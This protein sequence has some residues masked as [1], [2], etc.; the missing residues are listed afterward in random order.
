MCGKQRGYK[1][2]VFV[3]AATKGVTDAFFVSAVKKGLSEKD[4]KRRSHHPDRVGAGAATEG[5]RKRIGGR[6]RGEA[7]REHG[8]F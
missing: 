2:F 8:G 1:S 5:L 3:S 4:R 7:W 6:W